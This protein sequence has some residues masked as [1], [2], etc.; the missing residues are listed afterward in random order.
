MYTSKFKSPEADSLFNAIMSLRTEEEC[1]RF[2]GDL[3]TISEIQSLI[4]RFHVAKLLNEGVTY[5][6]I[7]DRTGA[8]TATISRVNRCL[9]YGE[10][11]YKEVLSRMK[12]DKK[13]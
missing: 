9:L 2:F 12:D 10:N 4:Q 7:S 11:G 8:S 3:C 5:T 1:Y 6:L 13:D